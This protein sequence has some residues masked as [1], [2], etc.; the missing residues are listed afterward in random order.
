MKALIHTDKNN[1]LPLVLLPPRL[2]S[3]VVVC[4]DVNIWKTFIQNASG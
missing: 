4:V 1:Y 3:L 2:T